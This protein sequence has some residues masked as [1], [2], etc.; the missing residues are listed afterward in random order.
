MTV[1]GLQVLMDCN[2]SVEHYNVIART[3]STCGMR[4]LPCYARVAK[5]KEDC[6][7]LRG[8]EIRESCA[9]VELQPLL[10]H[11]LQRAVLSEGTALDSVF[12]GA[13]TKHCTFFC[14]FGYDAST[15]QSSWQKKFHQDLELNKLDRPD[16]S[17]VFAS[18]NPL[19]LVT[20]D[21]G[22]VL[23][24]NPVPASSRFVR[25][26]MIHLA[27]ETQEYCLQ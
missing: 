19:R 14:A 24:E 6:R 23:W 8:V 21:D 13:T 7:P 4:I 20:D 10:D 2:M 18:M 17:V 15:G 9:R 22:T 5:S 12:T 1:L 26:I 27:K 3:V 16:H 25:P 11:T